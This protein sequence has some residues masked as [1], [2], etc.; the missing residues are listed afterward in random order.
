MGDR[1]HRE[2]VQ[3]AA[4]AT[5]ERLYAGLRLRVRISLRLVHAARSTAYKR[6]LRNMSRSAEAILARSGDSAVDAL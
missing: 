6:R 2:I 5:L 4:N 3:G 1:V